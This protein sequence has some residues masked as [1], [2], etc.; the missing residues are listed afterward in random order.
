MLLPSILITLPIALP[1]LPPHPWVAHPTAWPTIAWS[2]L[3]AAVFGASLHYYCKSPPS[4]NLDAHNNKHLLLLMS[5][6]IGWVVLGLVGLTR[7]SAVSWVLGGSAALPIPNLWSPFCFSAEVWS[8]SAP[9]PCL[10]P[11]P[12][13]YAVRG[14]LNSRLSMGGFSWMTAEF[15]VL[16]SV[17]VYPPNHI[18]IHFSSPLIA[19]RIVNFFSLVHLSEWVVSFWEVRMH[20]LFSVVS[21]AS[22][23][24]HY[25]QQVLGKCLITDK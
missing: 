19:R 20:C 18:P 8:S 23:S 16:K 25:V 10:L 17:A 15:F 2:Y 22:S 7:V 6:W 1:P 14:S 11:V 13:L 9:F 4:P 24:T 12:Q 5:L 3:K 21:P